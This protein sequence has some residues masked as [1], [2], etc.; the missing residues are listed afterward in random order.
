M[1]SGYRIRAVTDK[2]KAMRATQAVLQQ[3]EF[4]E[5]LVNCYRRYLETCEAEVKGESR[6]LIP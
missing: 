2:E 1:R 4:E 3:R 5:G 6:S